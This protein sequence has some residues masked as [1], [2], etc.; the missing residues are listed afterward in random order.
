MPSGV[1]EFS[2]AET[3]EAEADGKDGLK[4]DFMNVR[5]LALG[6]LCIARQPSPGCPCCSQPLRRCEAAGQGLRGGTQLDVQEDSATG[7][8][9]VAPIFHYAW[10]SQVI[11]EHEALIAQ[12]EQTGAELKRSGL[13][14]RWLQDADEG[15]QQVGPLFD[16]HG[17]FF[18]S[19]TSGKR[20]SQWTAL[21]ASGSCGRFRRSFVR[22]ASETWGTP[23]RCLA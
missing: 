8:K 1:C 10:P 15:S 23:H 5:F 7:A 12:I 4:V 22:G 2:A 21:G 16:Q 18:R 13:A 17:S 9:T 19:H 3:L 6:L 20:R 11:D 14:A